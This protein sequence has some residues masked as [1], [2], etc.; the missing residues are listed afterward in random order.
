MKIEKWRIRK[1][2]S[3]KINVQGLEAVETMATTEGKSD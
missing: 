1:I 2:M 3:D